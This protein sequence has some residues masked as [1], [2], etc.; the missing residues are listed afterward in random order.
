MR[1][2]TPRRSGAAG[3]RPAPDGPCPGFRQVRCARAKDRRGGR[4][5]P[6]K[7]PGSRRRI[8]RGNRRPAALYPQLLFSV[9][10]SLAG[11]IIWDSL[12][13]DYVRDEPYWAYFLTQSE[14]L[15]TGE[16]SYDTLNL[17][18]VVQLPPNVNT[19]FTSPTMDYNI[20]FGQEDTY[21][22]DVTAVDGNIYD[23][24]SLSMLT[25]PNIGANPITFSPDS[26]LLEVDSPFSWIVTCEDIREE[27]YIIDFRTITSR[28]FT[29]DTT[30]LPVSLTVSMPDDFPTILESPNWNNEASNLGN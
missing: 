23:T 27:P 4:S 7:P 15:C 25:L 10:G 8:S 20:I 14:N 12:T 5:R 22:F 2:R 26:A 21:E 28:C 13:C 1:A 29:Q 19:I 3:L 16:I 9:P 18:I 24:L 30:Y 6:K 17:A 11:N